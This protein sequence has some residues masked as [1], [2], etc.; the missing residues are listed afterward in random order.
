MPGVMHA[1]SGTLAD[2]T[3]SDAGIASQYKKR[4]QTQ[5]AFGLSFVVAEAGFEPTTFG[6]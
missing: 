5:F 6:L 4:V 2:Y 3:A 1:S